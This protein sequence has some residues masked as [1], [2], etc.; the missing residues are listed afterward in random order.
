MS[1]HVYRITLFSCDLVLFRFCRS[2]TLPYQSNETPP[3]LHPPMATLLLQ[4]LGLEHASDPA[5]IV[6]AY[7]NQTFLAL[8]S[9]ESNYEL[10]YAVSDAY[11]VLSNPVVRATYQDLGDKQFFELNHTIEYVDAVD[12]L[13]DSFGVSKV[14]FVT[15]PAFKVILQ[16][17]GSLEHL[18]ADDTS[19]PQPDYALMRRSTWADGKAK[20]EK[21]AHGQDYSRASATPHVSELDLL[22]EEYDG[23]K[24]AAPVQDKLTNMFQIAL[25]LD[26]MNVYGSIFYSRGTSQYNKCKSLIN[27]H[28]SVKCP[29]DYH[30]SNAINLVEANR[31]VWSRTSKSY[32][33]QVN[34]F[35]LVCMYSLINEVHKALDSTLDYL[36][37]AQKQNISK[38]KDRKE[39]AQHLADL[40][41]WMTDQKDVFVCYNDNLASAMTFTAY[42]LAFD[43]KTKLHDIPQMFPSDCPDLPKSLT[44]ITLEVKD[45]VDY[46]NYGSRTNYQNRVMAN[47]VSTAG[48][49]GPISH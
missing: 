49:A 33:D 40:G 43:D 9:L 20:L 28:R 15:V 17:L 23:E 7:R 39:P 8:K 47:I 25:G 14:P 37:D 18:P 4:V 38:R 13:L 44:K 27:T 41:T 30:V 6:Q 5:E 46:D 1:I 11:Q 32:K 3:A 45:Y 19:H 12:L 35:Y 21:M 16:C 2:L 42:H 22:L 10:L 29:L 31:A 26:W 48:L 34:M 36:F 24:G